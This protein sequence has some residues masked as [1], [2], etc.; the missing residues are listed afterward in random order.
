MKNKKLWIILAAA[1]LCV[2]V[3][4]GV[5]FLIPKGE[6]QPDG[7]SAL[8]AP[9]VGDKLTLTD[10]ENLNDL[11]HIKQTNFSTA[12]LGKMDITAEQKISG[13]NSLKYSYERGGDPEILQRFDQSNLAP[14]FAVPE[15]TDAKAVLDPSNIGSTSLS[16]YNGGAEDITVTL[17]VVMTGN[18]VLMASEPQTAEAGQWTQV[19]FDLD[20][21]E[22]SGSKDSIIGV[23]A[24]LG[25]NGQKGDYY[26][27]NW[28]VTIG[29]EAT[30][31]DQAAPVIALIDKLPAA[32]DVGDMPSVI[33]VLS[34]KGAYDAL[35]DSAKAK[36]TNYAKLEACLPKAADY[37]LPFDASSELFQMITTSGAGW[38]WLGNLRN[39]PDETFGSVVEVNVVRLGSASILELFHGPFEDVAQYDQ[40]RFYVYNP[41]DAAKTLIYATGQGWSGKNVQFT[42]EPQQWTEVS[43]SVKDLGQNG[44]YMLIQSSE[45]SGWRFSSFVGIRASV[46]AAEVIAMIDALP[47]LE[48]ATEAD[49]PAI[50]AALDAYNALSEGAQAMVTNYDKLNELAVQFV[51][52]SYAKPVIGAIDALYKELGGTVDCLDD[53]DAIN[54]VKDQYDSILAEAKMAVTNADKL[55]DLIEKAKTYQNSIGAVKEILATLDGTV[56]TNEEI[57]RALSVRSIFEALPAGEQAKLSAA[58]KKTYA[59]AMTAVADYSVLYD[60]LSNTLLTSPAPGDYHNTSEVRNTY[61]QLYGNVFALKVLDVTGSAASFKPFGTLNTNDVAAVMIF[62]RNDTGAWQNNFAVFRSDWGNSYAQQLPGS[63]QTDKSV[64]SQ[65]IIPVKDFYD[66]SDVFYVLN[67]AG[68]NSE[69]DHDHNVTRGTWMIS[70]VIGLNWNAFNRIQAMDTIALIDALPNAGDVS[71]GHLTAIRAAKDAFDALKPEAQEQVTNADKLEACL[72]AVEKQIDTAAGSIVSAIE[73]L[74]EADKVTADNIMSYYAQ[75]NAVKASYDSAIPEIQ[76]KVTNAAKLQALTEKCKEFMSL[77]VNDMIESLP[78][79]KDVDTLQEIMRVFEAQKAYDLLSDAD[80]AK[81]TDANKTKLAACMEKTAGYKLLADAGNASMLQSGRDTGNAGTA[82]SIADD[83][84]GTVFSLSISNPNANGDFH[85]NDLDFSGLGGVTF[86][87]YNPY[88]ADVALVLYDASWGGGEVTQAKA[89]AWTQVTVDVGGT[90]YGEKNFFFVVCTGDMLNYYPNA[91]A[92]GTWK[93]TGF[94][95][96]ENAAFDE[97]A[98]PGVIAQIEALPEAAAVTLGDKA[99]IQAAKAAYDALNDASK[100]KITNVSKLNDCVKALND[101]YKAEADKIIAQIEALPAADQINGQNVM[102]HYADINAVK[103]A[104]DSA[105][106]EIQALVTNVNKLN[107]LIATVDS[108][109]YQVIN[110]LIEKLPAP[111]AVDA[112]D[113]ILITLEVNKAY[114]LLTEEG[115][116]GIT[117]ANKEKLA[118]CMAKTSAYTMLVD[119]KDPTQ[120]QSGRDT[121]NAGTVVSV[122]DDTFVSAFSLSISNPNANGDFHANMDLTGQGAVVFF[123]YNPYNEDVTLAMYDSGWGGGLTYKAKARQ[124]TQITV[125]VNGNSYG[126]KGFFFIV[127]AGDMLSANPDAV[128]EGTWKITGFLG[129]SKEVMDELEVPNVIAQI[130]ALPEASTVTLGDKA[131]IQAAKAAYDA[132][133]DNAKTKVTNASKL[134]DCVAALDAVFAAEAKQVTDLIDALPEASAVTMDHKDAIQ[135]ARAAL[136]DLEIRCKEAYALVSDAHILKLTACEEALALLGPAQLIIDSIG[137]VPAQVTTDVERIQ[138]LSLKAAID[139]QVAA[140]EEADRNAVLESEN[141][142]NLQALCKTITDAGYSIITDTADLDNVPNVGAETGNNGSKETLFVNGWGNVYSITFNVENLA[143]SYRLKIP[144]GFANYEQVSFAVYNPLSDTVNMVVYDMGWGNAKVVKISANSWGVIT[145][146]QVYANGFFVIVDNAAASTRPWYITGMMGKTAGQPEEPEKPE[147]TEGTVLKDAASAGQI[148]VYNTVTGDST[149][150]SVAIGTDATHGNVFLITYAEGQDCTKIGLQPT[151]FDMTGYERIEFYAFNPGTDAITLQVQEN[152]GDWAIRTTQELAPGTWTKVTVNVA[153][154][155]S[156]SVLIYIG[157]VGGQEYKLSS[158]V[159]YKPELHEEGFEVLVDPGTQGLGVWNGGTNND[160]GATVSKGTNSIYG[161]VFIVNFS[162]ADNLSKICLDP[163]LSMNGYERVEFYIYNPGE[164]M[165]VTIAENGDPWASKNYDVGANGWTKVVVNC[166]DFTSATQKMLIYIRGITGVDYKISAIVGYKAAGEE[167]AIAAV[168]EQITALPEADALTVA[169]KDAVTAAKEAFDALSPEG[170]TQVPNAAKLTVC[171]NKVNYWN[172]LAEHIVLDMAT[173]ALGTNPAANGSGAWMSTVPNVQNN[174]FGIVGSIPADQAVINVDQTK[175][176]AWHASQAVG[177]YIYNPTDN[178]VGGYYTMDWVCNVNFTL[179]AK[180]WSY[181]EFKDLEDAS[182][183]SDF[184]SNTASTIWVYFNATGEGWLISSFYSAPVPEM[185]GE[186]PGE[187]PAEKTVLKDATNAGQIYVYNTVTGDSTGATVTVGTDETHGN[188]FLVT[189]D[190]G[191]DCSK[192]GLQPVPFDMSGY[193]IVEFYVYNPGAEPITVQVQENGGNWAVHTTQELTPGAWTKVT[194]NV[195]DYA[196]AGVLIYINGVGGQQYKISS[197]VAE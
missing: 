160:Q 111:E 155:K 163:A 175:N 89:R 131:A 189:Y 93:I 114:N 74:P 148:Y 2:A 21:L 71:L 134:N 145:L 59:E 120:L 192:I 153:D 186:E 11:Y 16:V 32:D 56:N 178:D 24:V 78:E 75:I 17:R 100:A 127:C 188:V 177:V 39:T 136:D 34:A 121:G 170:Q 144:A 50:Q 86:F 104:Y 53:I 165:Q 90:A 52:G 173:G 174:T 197:I 94:V 72:A 135:A 47:A 30:D 119:A 88:D 51:Y 49:L 146:E 140:L 66:T 7:P 185:P 191:Q 28:T 77:V 87:V 129:I 26:I 13:E 139:G 156:T 10:F 3:I 80:K 18:I 193:T 181:V 176:D 142:K 81:I 82:V 36:V 166:A 159:G 58:E 122:F 141:Y 15:G 20:V 84:F 154:Y 133:S 38:D 23:S 109:M 137:Q 179:K 96:V 25:V 103:A 110:S 98:V 60:A 55:S 113:E 40:I 180:A 85:I 112:A 48:N 62:V 61:D 162:D 92:E 57:L 130:E 195:A 138:Y 101:L 167:E 68:P 105:A 70:S 116:A 44:S 14:Y 187:T 172:A 46:R 41:M 73:K 27:D 168:I 123:V 158:I 22:R 12:A 117:A 107:D 35:S 5:L 184:V 99:A 91:V 95:G 161:N 45:S 67:N 183:A 125:D 108:N 31:E 128:A 152:G 29:A 102:Q 190:E 63:A 19:S 150:A 171:V 37:G 33:K 65:I 149:G 6:D 164:A 42:L 118:A 182:G 124:W 76:A 43:L 151:P 106:P 83:A 69:G 9:K 143:G 54:K 1:V 157:G 64:W 132:L 97:M 115:K 194:V 147:P 4:L 169:D 126:T 79:P 8:T 196:A